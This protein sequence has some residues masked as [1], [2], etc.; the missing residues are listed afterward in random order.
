ML[1]F[2]LIARY[3]VMKDAVSIV[4]FLA[5]RESPILGTRGPTTVLMMVGESLMKGPGYIGR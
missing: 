3:R 4:Q 2:Q 5:F 1:F